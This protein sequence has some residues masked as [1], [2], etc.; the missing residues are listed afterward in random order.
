VDLIDLHVVPVILGGGIP[1]LSC[2]THLSR[3]QLAHTTAFPN[4]VVRISYSRAQ[5]PW[6]PNAN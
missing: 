2:S 6:R 1:M 3:F 4:G 5:R